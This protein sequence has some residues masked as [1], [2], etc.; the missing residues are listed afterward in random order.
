MGRD[1]LSKETAGNGSDNVFHYGPA[2][3]GIVEMWGYNNDQKAM[4]V[5]MLLI[6]LCRH[7]CLSCCSR[8]LA[9]GQNQWKSL[10]F[11]KDYNQ[12]NAVASEWWWEGLSIE[13]TCNTRNASTTWYISG[14]MQISFMLDSNV[15]AL[16]WLS[17]GHRSLLRTMY[18]ASLPICF[19][20][21][22]YAGIQEYLAAISWH[23]A[24]RKQKTAGPVHL[25]VTP[26]TGAQTALVRVGTSA[27]R[28]SCIPREH[29]Y[30][31]KVGT[32]LILL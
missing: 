3:S 10:N 15:N 5:L 11:E 31:S 30:F 32:L 9:S 4:S 2:V 21:R 1:P 20:H 19:K 7:S 13:H 27:F 22:R 26:G 14:N 24:L 25:L 28:C 29:G 18:S 23:P 16:V 6:P 12:R 8:K 17:Y